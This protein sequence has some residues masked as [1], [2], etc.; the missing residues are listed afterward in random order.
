MHLNLFN[1]IFYQNNIVL[2]KNKNGLTE[3]KLFVYFKKIVAWNKKCLVALKD[4]ILCIINRKLT[5]YYD[6]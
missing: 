3:G 5:K 1:N 2:K 4:K 6:N